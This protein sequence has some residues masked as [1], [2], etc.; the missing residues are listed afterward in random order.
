MAYDYHH[1]AHRFRV[2]PGP[3]TRPEHGVLRIPG[4]WRL[5]TPSVPAQDADN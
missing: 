3:Q 1:Q 5:G 4:E 2:L